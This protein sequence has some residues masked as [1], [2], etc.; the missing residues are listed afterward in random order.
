M[1]LEV[2]A[3]AGDV[4]GDLKAVSEAHTGNLA[5]GGVGLLGGHG[6]D[7]HTYAPSLR[8]AFAPNYL[9][10]QG[11]MNPMHSRGFGLLSSLDAAFS[12]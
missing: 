3:F 10:F 9:V 8:G 5:E 12:Y 1:L 7:L 11:I 2:V 6:S 4:C